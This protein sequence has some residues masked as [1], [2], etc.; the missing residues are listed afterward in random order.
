MTLVLMCSAGRAFAQ[1]PPAGPVV[2]RVPATPRVA[3]LGNAWVAGSDREVI[4]YNPAQIGS[5]RTGFDLP[6]TFT[7][8]D[9]TLVTLGSTYTA[10]KWSLTLGWGAE[11]LRFSHDPSTVY[12]FSPDIL[13]ATGSASATSGAFAGGGV[14]TYK[15][16]RIGGAGKYAFDTTTSAALANGVAPVSQGVFVLDVG[17]ARNKFGGTFAGSVQNLAP[18]PTNGSGLVLPRQTLVGY[19]MTRAAGPLDLGMY[20]QLMFR[21]D[22]R[23]PAAGLEA[24]YSW[25]EGYNVALRVGARRPETTTEKPIAFG[26][27]ITADRLSLEYSLQLFDGGRAAHGV[28]V[29]WR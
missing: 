7:G 19:S 23:S 24:G 14:I 5:A 21:H 4:F 12:P 1:A 11:F 3:A 10:G 29:R 9:S 2:L 25:I 8:S 28:T 27:A 16:F 20:S 13:T 6:V 26:A 15:G 22:W 18:N 17:V